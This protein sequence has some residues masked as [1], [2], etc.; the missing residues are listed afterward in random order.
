MEQSELAEEFRNLGKSINFLN[1]S[2]DYLNEAVRGKADPLLGH[3]FL[4][5]A[6]R[7]WQGEVVDSAGG[8]FYLVYLYSW[9]HGCRTNKKLVHISDMASWEFYD[10]DED[11]RQGYK[12]VS[13][14]WEAERQQEKANAS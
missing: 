2:V 3:F 4:S 11:W 1:A 7:G 13:L 10:N 6:D 5:D 12:H 8:G 9:I 14:R